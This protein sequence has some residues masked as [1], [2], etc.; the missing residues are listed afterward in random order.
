MNREFFSAHNLSIIHICFVEN[1]PQTLV[2]V[3]ENG[4]IYVWKYTQEHLTSKQ[5]FDP[6]NRFR[7][8]LNYP[9]YT[10]LKETRVFPPTGGKDIDA[11]KPVSPGPILN[12]V[13]DYMQSN[14]ASTVNAPNLEYD[15]VVKRVSEAY[16]NPKT[17]VMTLIL[18]LNKPSVNELEK[19]F[20]ELTY[21]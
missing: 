8:D 1:G 13:T 19:E 4:H 18:P 16:T 11:T 15:T 10:K 6:A 12:L 2:T 3:D 9:K 5:R 17:K 21:N 7:I 14:G 20:D